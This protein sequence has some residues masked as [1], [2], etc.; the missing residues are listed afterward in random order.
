MNEQSIKEAI[1]VGC[2]FGQYDSVSQIDSVVRWNIDGAMKMRGQTNVDENLMYTICRKVS[3][4]LVRDYP[5][6]T[7]KE[8]EIMLDAGV[9]GEFTKDTWVSGGIIL[10]WLRLYNQHQSRI[11]V[12]DE[13]EKEE[14]TVNRKT[15]EEITELNRE[16]CEGKVKTAIEFC[17]KYGTIFYFDDKRVKSEDREM[18]FHL[19]Q[20][21]AVTYDWFREQGRIPDPNQEQMDDAN[22]YA[23][24]MIVKKAVRNELVESVR[25]DWYKSRL[26][27]LFILAT[28]K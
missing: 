18:A 3:D 4:T 6:M 25:Q 13:Q 8:F 26:L 12:I 21:A 2:P 11:S 27:E 24:E 20:F 1:N 16:A 17:R 5:N 9:S 28:I 23:D 19:P 22:V 7:D 14:K 15:K 10:Q